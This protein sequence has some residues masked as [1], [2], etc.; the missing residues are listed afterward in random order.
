MPLTTKIR[1]ATINDLDTLAVL[2]N[3][4][5]IFYKKETDITGATQFLSERITKNESELYLS[6]TAD[7]VSGFIQLYPLF[8]ST[9]MKRLWILNDLYVNEKFRNQGVGSAL[10]EQ[11]KTLCRQ[12]GARGFSLVTAKTNSSS[13]Q[14]YKKKLELDTEHNFYYWDL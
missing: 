11:A 4:Y 10:I 13:N 7:E 14:L 9:Q 1:K 2:F 5:R 6:F 12:S 3:A 8:S